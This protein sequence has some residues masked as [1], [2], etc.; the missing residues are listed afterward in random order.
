MTVVGRVKDYKRDVVGT[1]GVISRSSR[2]VSEVI[3]V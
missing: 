1:V 3:F 2:Y